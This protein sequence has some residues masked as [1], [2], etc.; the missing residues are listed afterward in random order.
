VEVSKTHDKSP[1]DLSLDYD[2]SSRQLKTF[3][4]CENFAPRDL[5]TFSGDWQSLNPWM[6]IRGTGGAS[7][8]MDAA[9]KIGY[10][11]DISGALPRTLPRQ[12]RNYPLSGA[13]FAVK[14]RG[15]DASVRFERLFLKISRGEITFRGGVDLAPFAPNGTLLVKDFSLAKRGTGLAAG[16]AD[17]LPDVLNA[18][19]SIITT[20]QEINA[21]GETVQVGAVELSAL[22]LSLYRE[23]EG[24]SF[25]A[26]ALRFT[27][28]ESYE[29]VS[30]SS[31]S[32]AGFLDYEG[33]HIEGNFLLDSFSAADL[34][35][36]L[37][38]FALD[39]ALP[40]MADDVSRAVS[41]TTEIFVNTD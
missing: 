27:D 6:S 12:L 9:G 39:L 36:L 18:E 34:S 22:D 38:P 10:A 32:L 1:L 16:S 37:K 25:T 26:S 14:G 29:Q 20:G 8:E 17:P 30:L 4:Q 11:A 24:F 23:D 40:A 13:S 21:F 33:P 15:D 35:A 28:I 5:V 2:L 31:L 7:F 41:I 19:L 3:F